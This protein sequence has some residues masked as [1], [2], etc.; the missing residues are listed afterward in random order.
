MS[1]IATVILAGALQAPDAAAAV[2]YRQGGRAVTIHLVRDS[3]GVA[4]VYSPTDAGAYFGAGYA[5]AGDRLFQMYWGRLMI[6]GR[7]AEF[8]GPG[9]QLAPGKFQYLE[10]DKVARYYGW[11][12]H[13]DQVI[14]AIDPEVAGLLQAYADGVN[15]Y[16]NSANPA[17]HPLFAQF[18]VPFDPWTAADCV[19]LW[20]RLARHFSSD[21]T[22]KAAGLHQFEDLV[23]QF[24]LDQAIDMMTPDVVY[25][26]AA[27]AVLQSDVPPA[28]QQAMAA[29][30]AQWGYSA[31]APRPSWRETPHFS[32]AWAVS[33]GKTTTGRAVLHSDPQTAIHVP[34]TFYEWHMKG[35]S[36]EVRGIGV[37]G[38]PNLIIGSSG[39]NAWGATALGMDQADL[40]E[41]T[42]DPLNHPN[43]Y[44]LDG[45]WLPYA[46]TSRQVILVQGQAPV[47]VV[48]RET[49]WGPEIT[50]LVSDVD[51]GEEY[52]VKMIPLATPADDAAEGY[53][54]MYRAQTLEQ[55]GAALAGVPYPSLNAVFA[56]ADG[57][58]GY[59]ANGANPLRSTRSPLGGQ[60]AQNG[61][62]THFDWLDIVPHE[63]MPYAIQPAAGFV[64]SGNHMPVGAWY[65]I[66]ATFGTGSHGDTTRSRRLR[67]RLSALGSFTPADVLAVHHDL[68]Q[69]ARRDLAELGLFLRDVQ[70]YPLSMGALRALIELQPWLASGAGMTDVHRGVVVAHFMDLQ[71]RADQVPTLVPIYG[72]GENGLN[73]FLKTK[74]AGIQQQ[75]P[76]LL[77]PDEAVWIN[78]V[79][80]RAHMAATVA[81]G[82]TSA[83]LSWYQNNVLR[84]VRPQWTSL[85]GFPPLTAVT[86]PSA[87]LDCTDGGTILSQVGQSYSQ[88][89]EVGVVDAAV[90]VLP[91][92]V[93]EHDA[94][95]FQLNQK[96][97]WESQAFK[98]SPTTRTGVTALGSYTVTVLQY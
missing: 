83:W 48:Y 69:P 42:V 25:D 36:F 47:T 76:V 15:A 97:L 74:I 59:W 37:A 95:A 98:P 40:F 17:I 77:Q 70:G 64:L 56:N 7:M 46:N 51:P 58:V 43:E 93:A 67:E 55:F 49:Y 81:A 88:N 31:S 96:P 65:P 71:F 14:A 1:W 60:I 90:S 11:R 4:H 24:G 80:G 8:F 87:Q 78:T 85:E 79:L 29:Y 91:F 32:H 57:R 89:W 19:A 5:A 86:Y 27:A 34:S 66:P 54:A 28:V 16:V 52:A 21:A 61:A 20:I 82:P 45:Q 3:Y 41:L 72:G 33:G 53:L 75:P 9:P 62:F 12:R 44:L 30:A 6:H 92:G 26:E 39:S 2:P 50:E 63:L 73:F 68:V 38:S 10:A 94:S 18:G 35:A 84:V 22:G 23:A 13:A